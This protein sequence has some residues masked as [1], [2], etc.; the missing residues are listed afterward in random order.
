MKNIE[1]ISFSIDLFFKWLRFNYDRGILFV[2]IIDRLFYYFSTFKFFPYFFI[3]TC[4]V[5][6]RKLIICNT[7]IR[8]TII[9]WLWFIK[10]L[11]LNPLIKKQRTILLTRGNLCSTWSYSFFFKKWALNISIFS[12]NRCPSLIRR[13]NVFVFE[14]STA[15]AS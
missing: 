3:P 9:V 11:S 6:F 13:L 15:G 8:V 14:C 4:H 10:R 1:K 2:K 12:V 7:Q 5:V